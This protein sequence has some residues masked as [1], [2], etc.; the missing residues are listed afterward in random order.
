MF[1]QLYFISCM[2][3]KITGDDEWHHTARIFRVFR[4]DEL[5]PVRGSYQLKVGE[6]LEGDRLTLVREDIGAYAN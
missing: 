2:M 6:D 1:V 3:Y 5:E 4:L